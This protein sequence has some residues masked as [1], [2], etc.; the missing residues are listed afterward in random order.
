[1]VLHISHIH[2]SYMNMFRSRYI[3]IYNVVNPIRIYP[4]YCHKWVVNIISKCWVYGIGFAT[5]SIF[6]DGYY[7]IIS[8]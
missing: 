3:Y 1:M 4:R 5:V 8:P 7:P 6:I 2:I